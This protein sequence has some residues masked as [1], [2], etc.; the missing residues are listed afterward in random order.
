[1]PL[2]LLGAATLLA[3]PRQLWFDS[4]V[5]MA[6][7][8]APAAKKPGVMVLNGQ[9]TEP[10][11]PKDQLLKEHRGAYTTARTVDQ[12]SVFELS[13][14]CQR[15]YDTAVA[16][17]EREID[18]APPEHVVRAKAFLKAAGP[19]GLKPLVRQEMNAALQ[20]LGVKLDGQ[21]AS[22]DS[23]DYQVTVLLTFDG[24]GA[25][26]PAERGFDVITF[27]QPLPVIASMVATEAHRADRKN[28]T[29]KD[30]QWVSDRS[31]LEEVQRAAGVNE[32][33]MFDAEGR[34]TEGLQTNFF[35]VDKDGALLTAPDE[36]VLS[37]TVR[38]VVLQVAEQNGIPI[39]YDCPVIADLASWES[40]FICSTS[41]LVK[42]ISQVAAPELKTVKIFPS[43]GSIAHRVETL[44]KDAIRGN[45]ELL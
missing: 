8:S 43:E 34:V 9:A 4:P 21:P 22:P 20:Q 29:I 12:S 24:V 40:C 1:M 35:A 28:P 32:L 44:V 18:D 2:A 38:K 5:T 26:T 42:P 19:E 15:L 17:L 16:V 31:R 10:N 11:M 13:M 36:R 45:S 3:R 14:H 23:P 30:L 27:V 33:I 25:H 6:T 41:R 39:R 37:G 7:L